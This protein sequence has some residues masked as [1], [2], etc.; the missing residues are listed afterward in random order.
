[1][2]RTSLTRVLVLAF[3]FLFATFHFSARFQLQRKLSQISGGATTWSYSYFKQNTQR[4]VSN[5]KA[6][7]IGETF[8]V[9]VGKADITGYVTCPVEIALDSEV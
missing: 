7:T 1:M 9:G 8:L 5:G 4:P 3:F 2:D 6:S